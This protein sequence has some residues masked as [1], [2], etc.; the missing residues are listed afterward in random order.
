MTNPVLQ[1]V[2]Q[3]LQAEAKRNTQVR[4]ELEALRY[5]LDHD[6]ARATRTVAETL[7][8]VQKVRAD[9][10]PAGRSAA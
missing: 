2:W 10:F 4:L 3:E 7:A 5:L 1:P 8:L 6:A 9:A